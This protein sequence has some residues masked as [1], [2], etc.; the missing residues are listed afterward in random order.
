MNK[1]KNYLPFEILAILQFPHLPVKSS[2]IQT[3]N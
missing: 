2:Y 3:F 1:E